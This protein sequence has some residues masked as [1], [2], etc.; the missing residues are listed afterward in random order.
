MPII[1][2]SVYQRADGRT[3]WIGSMSREW[4]ALVEMENENEK[5]S[6]SPF[7]F[8]KLHPLAVT[9]SWHPLSIVLCTAAASA[10]VALLLSKHAAAVAPVSL[11][12]LTYTRSWI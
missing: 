1:L 8:T 6:P 12:F 2:A 7:P 9:A 10:F 11:L 3:R 4:L 5:F